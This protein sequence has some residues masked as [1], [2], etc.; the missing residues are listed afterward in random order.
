M[1]QKLKVISNITQV[2]ELS[3][4][5][6]KLE[7]LNFEIGDISYEITYRLN[8]IKQIPVKGLSKTVQ[9]EQEPVDVL[10]HLENELNR[11]NNNKIKLQDIFAH[12]QTII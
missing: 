3:R 6:G 8:S 10:T 7:S 11:L 2:P 1:E 5:I 4:L 9:T 12:I